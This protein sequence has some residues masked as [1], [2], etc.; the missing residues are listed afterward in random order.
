[1]AP[2]PDKDGRLRMTLIVADTRELLGWILT[3]GN[4]VR[5][6]KAESPLEAVLA[7]A[8]RISGHE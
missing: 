7:D 4:R 2:E 3:F 5:V 6:L 8:R 1:M